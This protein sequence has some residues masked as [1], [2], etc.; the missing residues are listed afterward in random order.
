M[1]LYSEHEICGGCKHAV[2]FDCGKCLKE[3]AVG[4]V[5]DRDHVRGSCPK[6]EK[7]EKR[8]PLKP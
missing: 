7:R 3:C 1:S 2:F 8:E 4:A 6:R 5:N